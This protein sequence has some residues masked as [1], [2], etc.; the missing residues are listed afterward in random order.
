[1]TRALRKQV[2]VSASPAA[3]FDAFTS[4]EGVTSFFAPAARVELAVGGAY[5]MHFM[6]EAPAGMRGSD[7]CQVLAF[8]RPGALSFSWNF[9][10]SLPAIRDEKTRVD[11]TFAAAGAEQT[12]VALVHS[13]WREGADWDAGFAYFDRAWDI[14][15]E[16]LVARFDS[17]PV[18][19][20]PP[21]SPD[22]GAGPEV[23][24]R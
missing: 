2:T 23:I 20:A 10:P 21:P 7:G 6:P 9:P 16:R 22:A 14:V 11:L 19:L 1:M 4:E 5:E 8:E 18:D 13:Q 24:V 17:G 12:R 15:L 3:V